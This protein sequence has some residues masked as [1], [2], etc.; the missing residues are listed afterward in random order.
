MR[1]VLLYCLF[2]IFDRELNLWCVDRI[3]FELNMDWKNLI[4]FLECGI[5]VLV[6]GIFLFLKRFIGIC[7]GV[8][9][10]ENNEEILCVCFLEIYILI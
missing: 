10:C 9:R 4:S 7:K 8:I 6:L 3:W 5:F 2:V 1:V